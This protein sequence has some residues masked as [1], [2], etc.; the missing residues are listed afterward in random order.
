MPSCHRSR[1]SRR[2]RRA[3]VALS[4]AGLAALG[5]IGLAPA[6]NA[7]APDTPHV[8]SIVSV[9][10][11]AFTVA[12]RPTARARGYVL[13][14]STV[15][16]DLFGDKVKKAYRSHLTASRHVTV[17]GLPYTS[18]PYYY[19]VEAFNGPSHRW[20]PPSWQSVGL[21]PAT[22][23]SLQAH[24][25]ASGTYLTWRSRSVTG[26]QI[27]WATDSAM[28]AGRQ[29][30]T[31]RGRSTTQYTPFGLTKG[32]RYYFR[33]R[34]LTQHT[35]S[36]W[37][38]QVTAVAQV[39]QQPMTLMTYNVLENT[40]AGTSE[41]GQTI[42][43]WTARQPA[44]VAL[45]QKADP[46]VI[47]VEEAAAWVGTPEGLGGTR[48]VDAL[49]HALGDYSLAETEIPPSQHH[50]RRL[51]DYILYKTADWRAVGSGGHWSIGDN[52]W[53]V[54]QELQN[55]ATGARVIVVCT[56]TIPTRGVTADNTRE[57]ETHTLIS[58]AQ[59]LAKSAGLPLV[60]AGDFNSEPVNHHPDGPGVA[61]AQAHMTDA[62]DVAAH[63]VNDKYNS[64]NQY[65]RTPPKAHSM[66][67]RV[68]V[69]NGV[70][71]ESHAVD[72][73]LSHG[74][75]VGVMPSDHNPVTVRLW[76]PY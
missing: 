48:Q 1:R 68:F 66:V 9:S 67:D 5:S 56:H 46:D 33:V 52:H 41:G 73:T 69:P 23:T 70:G 47:A 26:F 43:E 54:Y 25:G 50:Y 24:A 64:Q 72:L 62:H 34:A 16:A 38:G 36:S 28:T 37:T 3:A 17:R 10:S 44:A 31:V 51:G 58:Q 11:S 14:A 76:Y 12:V 75:F 60:Y 39:A 42:P 27:E 49:Q 13:Y 8:A 21:R 22:P 45:I 29:V 63:L 59:S 30:V 32:R 20:E 4:V 53:G 40:L 15:H 74:K 57:K 71:V 65:L 6:A 2:S 35:P 55:R 18:K 19:R 7:S 61:M